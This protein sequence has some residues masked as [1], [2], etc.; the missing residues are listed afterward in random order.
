MRKSASRCPTCGKAAM[1][2]VARDVTTQ[3]GGKSVVVKNVAVEECSQC[4]ERLYD[5]AALRRLAEAS[6]TR[7]RRRPAA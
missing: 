2:P 1:K 7:S 4:G 5:L 6:R 3:R